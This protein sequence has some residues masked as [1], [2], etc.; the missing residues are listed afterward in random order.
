MDKV[1]YDFYR[2]LIVT[3]AVSKLQSMPGTEWYNPEAAAYNE[4]RFVIELS[5]AKANQG[6]DHT[7]ANMQAQMRPFA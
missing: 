7:R 3:G 4:R 1:L 5:K 2:E 6:K